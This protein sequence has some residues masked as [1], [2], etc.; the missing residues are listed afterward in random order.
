M[1]F[2]KF[3]ATLLTCVVTASSMA[4]P[5]TVASRKVLAAPATSN[6][7]SEVDEDGIKEFVTRMYNI[8]LDRKAEEDGLKYWSQQ[9][10][11]KKA[12]GNSVACGFVFSPEFQN[13]NSTDSEFVTYMY[14]AFFGRSPEQDGLKYWTDFL[15]QGATREIVFAG[16]ANSPEFFD[17]CNSYGVV[18]GYYVLGSDFQKTAYVNLFVERL[19]NVLLDRSCDMD[20]MAYWTTEL[21]NKTM[22]GSMAAYGYVFSPEFKSLHTCNSCYVEKLYEAFLGRTPDED[23]KAYWVGLLDS[24]SSR[25]VVFNGYSRSPEF[26]EICASYGIEP[27]LLS[28]DIS[29]TYQEGECTLPVHKGNGNSGNPIGSVTPT[30]SVNNQPTSAPTATPSKD[31]DVTIYDYE[32]IPFYENCNYYVLVKT[33]NPD[34]D[35]FSLGDKSSV[36]LPEDVSYVTPTKNRFADVDYED[37]ETGRFQ[38]GYIC[39]ALYIDGGELTVYQQS[40]ENVN[41]GG[42]IITRTTPVETKKTITS[43]KLL[44]K[45]DLVINKSCDDKNSYFDNLSA[46]Q[47]YLNEYAIYPIGLLDRDKP[48]STPYLYL[49]PPYYLDQHVMVSCNTHSAATDGLLAISAYPFILHSISFP[50]LM[51]SVAQR[52]SPDA[53]VASNSY[54]HYLVDVTYKGETKSFGGQGS[55]GDY[56]YGNQQG[57]ESLFIDHITDRFKKVNQFTPEEWFKSL[58][59]DW[60]KAIKENEK[61]YH[62]VTGTGMNEVTGASGAWCRIAGDYYIFS[63]AIGGYGEIDTWVDGRYCGARGTWEKGAKFEDYPTADIVIT[64]M[65]YTNYKGEKL[66]GNVVFEYSKENDCWFSARAYGGSAPNNFSWSVFKFDDV[67]KNAPELVLTKDQVK[68]MKLDSKTDITPEHGF[69]YDGTVYPGTSF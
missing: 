3:V 33:N 51:A 44:D 46:A 18:R 50:S 28:D 60:N 54:Y 12:T 24:G 34:P 41:F 1:I 21:T 10:I 63:S 9:L 55:H 39:T 2:K 36:Y 32:I 67:K 57:T 62:F 45:T 7:S 56:G 61:Q 8:C 52:L 69:V 65:T 47:K 30:G 38:G 48:S 17:L 19:Y 4:I 68:A 58:Y 59:N 53:Q 14:N 27:G 66:T 22:T 25:E 29:C 64:N 13:K 31:I 43:P 37:Y 6:S 26:A 42:N 11:Q 35:S 23:G 15:K 20:G 5:A 40:H 49:V 16:F